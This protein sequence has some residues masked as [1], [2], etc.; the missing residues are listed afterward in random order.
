MD[1]TDQTFNE[2]RSVVAKTIGIENRAESLTPGSPLAGLPEFDSMA[3]LDVMLAI[4]E[5]FGVT[6]EDDEVTGDLF[7]TLGTLAAFVERKLK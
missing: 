3:V 2:V 6:I 1:I 7:E 5:R 4:E